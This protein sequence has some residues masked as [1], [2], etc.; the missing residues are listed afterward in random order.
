[1]VRK[2]S[3]SLKEA[4]KERNKRAF[5]TLQNENNEKEKAVTTCCL[6]G[7]KHNNNTGSFPLKN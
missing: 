6:E 2:V 3:T 7:V 1:M 5:K 4:L